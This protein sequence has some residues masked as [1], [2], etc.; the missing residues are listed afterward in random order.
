M[1]TTPCHPTSVI[2]APSAQQVEA[3]N[4]SGR[5]PVV[6]VHGLWL[7]ASSWDAWREHFESLGYATLAPGW[8][9]DPATVEEARAHPEVFAGKTVGQVTDH[10]A[11]VIRLLDRVPVV[12]GHS[13]G[14]LI[15]QKLAGMGLAWPPSPS[16]RP[17]SEACCRCRCRPCGRAR[18]CSPTRPTTGGTSH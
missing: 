8:P 18:R 16:T 3:A 14:G 12:I 15:T 2:T 1:S 4:A 6:F 11:D 7:L 13:F 5:Q 9:D 10:V 17:R